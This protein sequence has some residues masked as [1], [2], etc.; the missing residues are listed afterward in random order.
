M[1]R[2]MQAATHTRPVPVN[3]ALALLVGGV[4]VLALHN[5][6]G[7]DGASREGLFDS[8][9]YGL[10]MGGATLTVIARGVVVRAQRAAWLTLGAGLACWCL[11][12]LYY[13]LLVEGRGA[14]G[15]SVSP[16]DALYLVFYPCCYVALVLLVGAH[17]Q[18]LRIGM[19]LDGLIGGL[20]AA[21]VGSAV[22][23]PSILHGA[24]GDT[25]SLGVALAYPIGDLLL[26]VFA[27]GALGM[28]GWR[29]G[30][31]WLLIAAAML[32]SAVADSSY[33]YL[34]ATDHYRVGDATQFL[35][36]ASAVL[37]ALA[38]WTPWPRPRRRRVED[39]RMVSVPSLS[40]LAALGVLIYGNF[41][42]TQLTLPPLVL[43]TA[44][45][46]A[47]CVQLMATVRENIAMLAGSRRLALTDPLTGLGNRRLLVE[48]LG[49]ACRRAS[50]GETWDLVLYDLNG[51]KRYNDTFGHPAGDALLSRLSDKLRAVVAPYGT[52]YRMG[53]DEFCVLLC[54]CA[55]HLDALVAASVAALSEQGPGFSIGAA[56]GVVSIPPELDDPGAVMQLAD[57]RLYQRKDRTREASAVHQLRDVLLQAFQERHP[58]LQKHQRGVGALVLEVGRRLAMDGEEL[59]VLARA[60]ELH[61]VGKI[62]IPDAI[63][64]KPGPLDD[65]EWL[66]MRRHTI[67]GERILKAAAA[68]RPVAELVRSSHERYDGTGYP[69]GLHG[70][71]IPLGARIIFVCDAFDAMIS[72]RSY[73]GAVTPVAAIAELRACA[74]TQFDPEVVEAFVGMVIESE[75]PPALARV[76]A[77]VHAEDAQHAL[78]AGQHH[79]SLLT[80]AAPHERAGDGRLD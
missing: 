46:L 55:K 65:E 49:I 79:R 73:S 53:G 22:I 32:A 27:L 62:A 38:A 3:L 33:L 6:A 19:W 37:L 77:S 51:F 1:Q 16:A 76:G 34:T 17:L 35:W 9:T 24:R 41:P 40:L 44:A 12:D 21:A 25:A 74:G 36:P 26:V 10:L 2:A 50:A 71:E 45:V 75:P 70:E 69:D 72:E 80:G 39:W 68:L 28:T 15:G 63:L 64:N 31:V 60:A 7:L 57:Q 66:F 4:G 8:A 61:D 14:A 43:A 78:P 29:P 47:V 48:D 23:L 67:L 5:L 56:H 20:A 54:D 11:G 59:D 52:A 30:R 58:D 42:Q 13:T 18:E